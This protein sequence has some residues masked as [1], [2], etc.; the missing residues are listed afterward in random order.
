MKAR[1]NARMNARN[2]NRMGLLHGSTVLYG[3]Q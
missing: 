1:M 3:R 2:A